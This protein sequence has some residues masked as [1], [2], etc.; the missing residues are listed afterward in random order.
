MTT[1]ED[2]VKD[3]R[4]TAVHLQS[5]NVELGGCAVKKL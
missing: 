1:R 2:A 4:I 3:T 5:L